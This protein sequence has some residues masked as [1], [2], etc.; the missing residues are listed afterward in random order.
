MTRG[1]NHSQEGAAGPVRAKA[2]IRGFT[3]IELMVTIAMVAILMALAAPSFSEATL[4]SKLAA[5]ANRLSASATLARSEAIKRN[6]T[7]TM[8]VSTDG[9]TCA[10]SGGWE[11]GWIV[12]T[13]TTVLHYEQAAPAGLTITDTTATAVSLSF[14]STGAGATTAEFRVCRLTPEV[15]AQERVVTVTATGRTSVKKTTTGTCA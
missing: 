3:L 8:C 7:I 10:G 9:L 11:Q 6:S 1:R 5:N 15:G 2:R 12:L 13:G 14:P 4:G